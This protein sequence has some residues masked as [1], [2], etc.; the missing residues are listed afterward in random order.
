VHEATGK[1]KAIHCG[2]ALVEKGMIPY[3]AKLAMRASVTEALTSRHLI[4]GR[5]LGFKESITT[6]AFKG[7]H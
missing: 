4:K 7:I 1:Y 6:P 2:A 5:S 3:Q